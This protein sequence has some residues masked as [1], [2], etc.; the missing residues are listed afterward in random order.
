MLDKSLFNNDLFALAMR[1][2]AEVLGFCFLAWKLYVILM[3]FFSLVIALKIVSIAFCV[4][5]AA[6]IYKIGT[7]LYAQ[8]EAFLLS[9]LF[10]VYFLSSDIFIG[11]QLRAFGASML[12]VFLYFFVKEK[13]IY[14]PLISL[15]TF[16]VYPPIVPMLMIQCFIVLFFL[17]NKKPRIMRSYVFILAVACL[18]I[19][20][21]AYFGPAG[22][23]IK[24]IFKSLPVF[25]QYKYTQGVNYPLNPYNPLSSIWYFIFNIN[26]YTAQYKYF[27][28]AFII[29]SL[30]FIAARRRRALLLPRQI[31]IML[32]ASGLSF[33]LLYP[34]HPT[35]ASRQFVFSI[36]LL[37]VF[38]NSTNL[39]NVNKIK[40]KPFVFLLPL[41]LVFILI[42][43]RYNATISVRKYSPVYDYI[44]KLPKGVMIAG[45]PGS[46]LLQSVPLFSKRTIF[47]AD[48]MHDISLL[49]YSGQ[50]LVERKNELMKAL[51]AGS[52]E[53]LNSFI[54]KYKIDYFLIEASRYSG[55]PNRQF[56]FDL[57]KKNYEFKIEID[58]QE[59][60]VLNTREIK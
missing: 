43:P 17:D 53:A 45:D 16:F 28:V 6:I 52:K 55:R 22:E 11:G 36:P 34:F 27:T 33:L 14:L 30:F 50:E 23:F 56:L 9:G 4:I 32:L 38:L 39:S 7:H 31:W 46:V 58:G 25:S 13:Y 59:I 57:A 54:G 44:E 35:F 5:C 60:I 40:D 47:Y 26:E 19:G 24:V 48:E 49:A 37:L 41:A 3:H 8:N 21:S 1:K 42:N 15:L 51:Y 12:I 29:L 20:L 2:Q 10:S 18:S